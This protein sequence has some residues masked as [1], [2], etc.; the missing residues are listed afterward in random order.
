MTGARPQGRLALVRT[1]DPAGHV[2]YAPHVPASTTSTSDTDDDSDG[3]SDS[4][5]FDLFGD[6]DGDDGPGTPDDPASPPTDSPAT[7]SATETTTA[8]PSPDAVRRGL[9]S[10]L[11]DSRTLGLAEQ[12]R[13]T[14][15]AA[16]GAALRTLDPGLSDDVVAT[17]EADSRD[18]VD[19]FLGE[20]RPYPVTIGGRPAELR[21]TAV[22]D[23]DALTVDRAHDDPR[24]VTA[25]NRENLTHKLRHNRD[26]RVEPKVTVTAMPGV[27]VGVG[28]SLPA[29]PVTEHPPT[30]RT[31]TRP[32]P[33]SRSPG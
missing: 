23:W 15:N 11:R 22:L 26:R 14:E 13:A 16:L 4:G 7:S 25:K 30:T 33:R 1:I 17:V 10:Y 5:G 6:D 29:A 9:P 2:T 20:G 32:P 12:L 19:Q 28:G 31:P 27:V 3:G 8:L 21:V 24:K 18:D